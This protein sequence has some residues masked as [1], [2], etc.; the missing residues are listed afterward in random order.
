[1]ADDRVADVPTALSPPVEHVLHVADRD[2]CVRFGPM[3]A[4]VWQGLC[5]SGL[6]VAVL[7]DDRDMLARLVDTPVE[8]RWLRNLG[9]WRAWDWD[10]YVHGRPDQ[11]PDLVHLWGTSELRRVQRWSRRERVPLIMHALGAAHVAHVMRAGLRGDQHVLVASRPL[12]VPLLSRF[13][14]AA[15]RCQ[16][17]PLA[18]APGVRGAPARPAGRTFSVLCVGPLA[19]SR[20]LEVLVDAV[21]ELRHKSC[22]VHV[23]VIGVGP[24]ERVIWRHIQSRQVQACV[25]LTD[26]ARLWEK[27]LPEIDACVIPGAQCELTIMPLL[28]MALG[29]LV[30]AARD[31]P[32]EWLIEDR[33]CWQFT[34][35][36]AL[37]LAYLLERAIEQPQRAA[38][39]GRLAADYVRAHHSIHEMVERLVDI[40]GLLCTR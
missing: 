21:A 30:I 12:A 38:E 14:M 32:A 13:P 40:Y 27:L 20:A 15:S 26:E 29:K 37:E 11:R 3:L 36:S 8:G 22:P 1:M 35:G 28:G 24:G 17:V 33:T 39:T 25:S 19:E 23:A 31:Q 34:P 9:G 18:I 2:T 4:Q 5:A 16:V 6:H 7:T 10:A